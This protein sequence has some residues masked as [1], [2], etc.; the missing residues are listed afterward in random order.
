M[1]IDQRFNLG[2]E[3]NNGNQNTKL[4]VKKMFLYKKN[5][6]IKT[7]LS[8]AHIFRK[9]SIIVRR[10]HELYCYITAHAHTTYCSISYSDCTDFRKQIL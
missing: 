9:S 3:Y 2:L 7:I 10:F 8:H 5:V 4:H 6:L 1:L